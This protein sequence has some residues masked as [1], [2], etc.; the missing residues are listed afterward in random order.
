MVQRTTGERCGRLGLDRDESR[1]W[2]RIDGILNSQSA[3]RR[4]AALCLRFAAAT[5]R[6]GADICTTRSWLLAD[7]QMD[8]APHARDLAGCTAGTYRRSNFY[9]TTADGRSGTRFAPKRWCGL[10]GGREPI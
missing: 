2:Q 9:N 10:L 6:P 5:Q 1:R 3:I 7:Q 8:V 4:C